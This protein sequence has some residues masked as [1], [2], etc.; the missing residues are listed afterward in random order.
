EPDF[1]FVLDSMVIADGGTIHA[2]S[3]CA[4][5]VEPEIAFRLNRPLRGPD[6]TI[7]EVLD[8]TDSVAAALEIVDSRIED[9]RITLV[10]TIADNAS[11]GAIVLGPWVPIQEVPDLREVA[12]HL[13]VN[14]VPVESGDG[15]AVLGHPAAAVA[16]LANTLSTFGGSVDA[17]QL[18]MSGSMTAAVRLHPGDLAVADLPGLGRVSVTVLGKD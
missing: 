5:R 18:V 15:S 9:W 14:D 1:G 3:L 17:G 12:S 2:S 7:E 11:S 10:D 4:P 8:A 13:F 16:W 6:V